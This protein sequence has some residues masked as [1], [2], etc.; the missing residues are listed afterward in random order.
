MV[1]YSTL[2]S[3]LFVLGQNIRFISQKKG[4][5]MMTKLQNAG[6]AVKASLAIGTITLLISIISSSFVMIAQKRLIN[7]MFNKSWQMLEMNLNNRMNSEILLIKEHIEFNARLLSSVLVEPMYSFDESGIISALESFIS[8]EQI[9]VIQIY[10]TGSEE[11]T[12]TISKNGVNIS[13]ETEIEGKIDLSKL[14]NE[15]VLINHQEQ[16]ELGTLRVYYSIDS[17]TTAAEQRNIEAIQQA[18]VQRKELDEK[19]E[20]V[21]IIQRIVF[22]ALLTILILSTMYLLHSQVSR[23]LRELANLLTNIAEG[24]GDLT[25]R[26][27]NERKDELGKVAYWFNTFV[28]KIRGTVLSINHGTSQLLI[29]IDEL[30]QATNETS[31]NSENMKVRANAISETTDIV[32]QHVVTVALVAQQ[33]SDNIVQ[34]TESV[35]ELSSNMQ[36]VSSYTQESSENMISINQNME[37]ISQDIINVSESIEKMSSSLQDINSKGQE[38]IQISLEAQDGAQETLKTMNQLNDIANNIGKIVKLIDNI[39]S[40]TNMLALNATI[41]AASAGEAGKGFA[42]VASEVK[43]LANQTTNANNSIAQQIQDVQKVTLTA[44]QYTE[45]VNNI[46]EQVNQI[47][48]D[49]GNSV[50]IQTNIASEV[51]T[52]VEKI[53]NAANTS[54]Q[55][56]Q[57]MNEGLQK[58]SNQIQQSSQA[59]NASA[60][61][62]SE[63]SKGA[64]EIAIHSSKAESSIQK[65]SANIQEVKKAILTVD[66]N[67]IQTNQNV[68][69]LSEIAKNLETLVSSFQTGEEKTHKPNSKKEKSYPLENR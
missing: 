2:V 43:D 28:E 60:K 35:Q 59:A 14:E 57:E 64:Q 51:S 10:E 49:I 37:G 5:T 16:G 44:L 11:S 30:N 3:Y 27:P 18:E 46:I 34:V 65:V 29:S 21:A 15:T 66:N 61:N 4:F 39:A 56:V 9:Q 58:I 23:P 20:S 41:E 1:D 40:Q 48:Q 67:V 22:I 12:Y 42:V 62:L 53:S 13:L 50:Q 38:A 55:S 32:I 45:K 68:D 63:G 54:A 33:T 47:N 25:K 52:T 6:I 7:E 8:I 26:L 17:F 36:T 19:V 31:E 24:D 69:T